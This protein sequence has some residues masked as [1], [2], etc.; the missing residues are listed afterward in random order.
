MKKAQ[1][2]YIAGD[3]HADRRRLN[4][5]IER[6][7]RCGERTRRLAEENDELELLLFVCGDLGFG[8]GPLADIDNAVDFALD[9][10]LKIYWC[11]GNHEN[12]DALDELEAEHPGE[13][14]MEVAPCVY[15]ARFGAIL[16]LL[17]GTR[18]MFCGKAESTDKEL[19]TAG[20][21]W[22]LQET[23]SERDMEKLP[24]P[25]TA[26][27][28]WI[29]SHTCPTAFSLTSEFRIPGPKDRDPSR[30]FLE[31]IRIRYRPTQ[32]WFGHYHLHEVG[33]W[34]GCRWAALDSLE[35]AETWCGRWFETREIALDTEHPS[36][37][38]LRE[39]G[40]EYVT[41]FFDTEFSDLI[42]PELISLGAIS[43]D[44]K[45][46]FYAEV[47]PLPEECSDFVRQRVLPQLTGPSCSE[48]ELAKRFAAWLEEFGTHVEL[49]ADSDY[50]FGLLESLYTKRK[51]LPISRLRFQ[52]L[53]GM[54][55]AG[56]HHAR[57]DAE[58]LR[59]RFAPRW[60]L[61]DE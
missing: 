5:F 43:A 36:F 52:R 22:W 18:V 51:P 37:F 8:F 23:I 15:F 33:T 28:H 57:K 34:D 10:R 45:R 40:C 2:I 32:W 11:A 59:Q 9:G 17:D 27:V 35:T 41:V 54:G 29:V 49:C 26:D 38:R 39:N 4:G 42:N 19:R 53:A 46:S 13:D 24:D 56:P 14:F 31:E 30:H 58:L 3:V 16:T 61:D 47:D 12:H 20:I 55:Y 44:G 60:M 7:I 48:D 25:D 50:D 6:E 1:R 21:D